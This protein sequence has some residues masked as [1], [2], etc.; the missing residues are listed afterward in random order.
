VVDIAVGIIIGG[1]F[2]KI[3]VSLVEDVLMVVISMGCSGCP[4]AS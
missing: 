3:V 1:A 2:G 4:L